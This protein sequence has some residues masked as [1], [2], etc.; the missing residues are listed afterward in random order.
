MKLFKWFYNLVYAKKDKEIIR[1]QKTI[2]KYL[3]I[4]P[5]TYLE[6][7]EK[8]ETIVTLRGTI[9]GL[10][11]DLKALESNKYKHAI[12]TIG[13]IFNEEDLKPTQSDKPS[14]N[15]SLTITE[16]KQKLSMGFQ[17]P[18][19]Q[20]FTVLNTNS[21]E[22]F[23]DANSLVAAE[24]LTVGALNKQPLTIGSICIYNKTIRGKN[25]KILHRIA[26]VS[27]TKVLFKGDNNFYYDPW[28][29]KEFVTHRMVGQA[30]AQQQ[31][32]GD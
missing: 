17:S 8:V 23:I 12:T 20:I 4:L 28:V 29:K 9:E 14:P 19:F 30:F 32:A 7:K 15:S 18:R 22:P 1:L 13:Q 21:M 2:K 6:V 27:D 16:A 3:I 10:R 25:L 5:Q 11:N 24:V 31:L 26:Q